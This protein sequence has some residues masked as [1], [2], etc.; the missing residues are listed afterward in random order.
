MSVYRRNDQRSRERNVQR[1]IRLEPQGHEDAEGATTASDWT[2]T[3]ARIG[4]QSWLEDLDGCD[5]VVEIG[6]NQVR[7]TERALLCTGPEMDVIDGHSRL[8]E[9]RLAWQDD[10]DK[11]SLDRRGQFRSEGSATG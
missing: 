6:H 1:L 10:L 8:A 11:R 3:C 5:D 9:E 4:T 2:K 7:D